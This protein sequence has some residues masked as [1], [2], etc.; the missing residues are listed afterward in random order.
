MILTAHGSA[1]PR[2]AVTTY[3]VAEQIR[4]ARPAL[5]VRVAFCEKQ[6]PNLSDVLRT[7]DGPA[8][9]SP[10]LLASAYHARVDI[11]E[12]IADTGADVIQADTLGEDPRLVRVMRERLAQ[13]QIHQFERGLGVLVVAVGS[14]HAAANARTA[15]LADVLGR[16]TRWSGVQVAY[17]TGPQPSVQDGID[18]LRERGARRI[19]VAPWFIAP[20][21]ITDRVAAIADAADLSMVA[22]LGAHRLV[23]ETVLDRFDTAVANR[24]AA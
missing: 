14:S 13:H 21:R 20:G 24:L 9:V 1:D 8:V 10:L 16:G 6:A 5:D 23:A 15:A 4:V 3:A 22:P 7:L 17:A 12:M 11:P 2:S 18:L 19:V